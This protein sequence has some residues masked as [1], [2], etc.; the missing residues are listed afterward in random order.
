MTDGP[1]ITPNPDGDGVILHLPDFT[2]LD[3]Q[4][5]SVDIGLTDD[6]LAA[7]RQLLTDGSSR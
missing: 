2:H 3:T 1:R 4:A 7:L 5:W 6:A